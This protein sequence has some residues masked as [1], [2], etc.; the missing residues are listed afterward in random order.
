MRK[1]VIDEVCIDL[2][3][4]GERKDDLYRALDGHAADVSWVKMERPIA[5]Y[6]QDFF[7]HPIREQLEEDKVK[8]EKD[9][10]D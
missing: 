5:A 7:Q 4:W 8:R 2:V 6:T 1:I 9:I 10:Q 3:L